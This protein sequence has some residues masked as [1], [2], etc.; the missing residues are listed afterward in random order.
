MKSLYELKQVGR[1]WNKTLI[2]FFQKISFAPIN[3]DTCILITQKKEKLIII[4][5]FVDNLILRLRNTD[6][7]K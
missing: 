4:D 1:L 5:V 6:A 2:K 3:I 7:L